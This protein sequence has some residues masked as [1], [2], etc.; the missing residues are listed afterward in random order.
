M[1]VLTY[2]RNP[3]CLVALACCCMGCSTQQISA[4]FARLMKGEE[5]L[6]Q[7]GNSSARLLEQQ[8]ELVRAEQ[9]YQSLAKQFPDR[10]EIY[11]RLG[12]IA[13]KRGNR[14]DALRNL[15]KAQALTPLNA[16][17]LADVGY[18]EYLAGN[19]TQAAETLRQ[20]QELN[21]THPR[22]QANLAMALVAAGDVA[23]AHRLF[24]H[25]EDEAGALVSLGFALIQHGK[26]DEGRTAFEKAVQLDPHNTRAAEA[27]VQLADM[28]SQGVVAAT[29]LSNLG[30]KV[31]DGQD[32]SNET[33]HIT[34]QSQSVDNEPGVVRLN[35]DRTNRNFKATL[36]SHAFYTEPDAEADWED[37]S[38]IVAS[39]SRKVQTLGLSEQQALPD[40]QFR[41]A[42]NSTLTPVQFTEVSEA[43]ASTADEPEPSKSPRS[44]SATAFKGQQLMANS[45]GAMKPSA[46]AANRSDSF[47][48]SQDAT[49]WVSMDEPQFENS[50][51][52]PLVA[53]RHPGR[54]PTG[55]PDGNDSRWN[56]A[57]SLLA[58]QEQLANA[59]RI[60]TVMLPSRPSD[61]RIAAWKQIQTLGS[62][63]QV[64]GPSLV[65]LSSKTEGMEAVESAYAI[66]TTYG[67][68]E[69]A[70]RRIKSLDTLRNGEIQ[71]QAH[72]VLQ[73]IRE[74]E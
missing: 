57:M 31:R 68:T 21:P 9:S 74:S 66:Y 73:L 24:R 67:W 61:Q 42:V 60:I 6:F 22:I 29:H 25:T 48:S 37:R 5:E 45:R 53:E 32:T 44:V 55:L 15:K 26:L 16:E 7:S 39:T 20:A 50:T 72:N 11:Q 40:G 47:G 70:E 62:S 41:R 35:R 58:D 51:E 2:L 23:T 63:A 14:E 12:I 59:L 18:A 69:Y 33:A 10:Y 54:F 43:S 17:V 27:I 8:C 34:G 19:Y 4:P 56:S 13:Q 3:F 28:P 46:K 1:D 36:S 64:A 71:R 30:I 38:S 52:V 49:G 65:E